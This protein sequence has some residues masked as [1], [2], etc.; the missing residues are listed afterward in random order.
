MR[1]MAWPRNAQNHSD[2]ESEAEAILHAGQALQMIEGHAAGIRRVSAVARGNYAIAHRY[3]ED[4]EG[5]L[6]TLEEV[7]R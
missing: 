4:Y 2:T 1:A 3:V 5:A 7:R 6:A